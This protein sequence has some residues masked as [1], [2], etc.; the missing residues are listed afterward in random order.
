MI[1]NVSLLYSLQKNYINKTCS[2]CFEK[3]FLFVKIFCQLKRKVIENKQAFGALMQKTTPLKPR[4][5]DRKTASQTQLGASVTQKPACR[6][7]TSNVGV[8]SQRLQSPAISI[9]PAMITLGC[10]RSARLP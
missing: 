6:S 7:G 4:P 8:L 10:L 1:N 5:H 9:T 2:S 3:M